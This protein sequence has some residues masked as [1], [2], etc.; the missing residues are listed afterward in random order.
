[1]RANLS[2]RSVAFRKRNGGLRPIACGSVRATCSRRTSKPRAGHTS[3]PWEK[4]GAAKSC[5]SAL[6]RSQRRTPG[7]W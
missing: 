7:A 5:V 6:R 4:Q 3:T 2:T 1:M